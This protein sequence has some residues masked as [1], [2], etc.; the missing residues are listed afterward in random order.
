[1]P[2]LTPRGCCAMNCLPAACMASTREGLMSVARMLP[3]TSITMMTVD[4]CEAMLMTAAGRAIPRIISAR[5]SR[6]SAGGCVGVCGCR[7]DRLLEHAE[8]AVAHGRFLAPPQHH[9][10]EPDGQR[11]DQQQP[12]VLGRHERDRRHVQ[13]R[14]EGFHHAIP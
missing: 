4:L 7:P 9:H 5:A 14:D 2:M 6:N 3:E 11:H 1:M 12:Q 8:I 10:I 13:S